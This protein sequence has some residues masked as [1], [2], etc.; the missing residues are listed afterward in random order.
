MPLLP[1]AP[2][3]RPQRH[4]PRE[5]QQ[6]RVVL[7]R[8][9]T[10]ILTGGIEAQPEPR[11]NKRRPGGG[12]AADCTDALMRAQLGDGSVPKNCR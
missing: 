7:D 3:T 1:T 6:P 12:G 4:E 5:I 8:K 10:G 9:S 2:G 11:N